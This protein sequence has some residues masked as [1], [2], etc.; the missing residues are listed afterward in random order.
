MGYFAKTTVLS[1][2]KNIVSQE[3][4]NLLQDNQ[5]ETTENSISINIDAIAPS[6]SSLPV[7]SDNDNPTTTSSQ[8]LKRTYSKP[9]QEKLA[10][11]IR[12]L[13][14]KLPIFTERQ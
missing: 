5:K 3:S 4:A 13:E 10:N 1:S 14:S 6:T 12:T 9:A 2:I 7:D 11:K 8:S